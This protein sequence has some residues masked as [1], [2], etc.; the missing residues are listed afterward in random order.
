MFAS[1]EYGGYHYHFAP[2]NLFVG[3]GETLTQMKN[4]A[5]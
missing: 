3:M 1:L 5:K 2:S 4:L